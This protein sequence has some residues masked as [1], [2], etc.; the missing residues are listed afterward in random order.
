MKVFIPVLKNESTRLP[1]SINHKL[2]EAGLHQKVFPIKWKPFGQSLNIKSNL[3][4][5]KY[6]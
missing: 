1:T 3:L 5:L 4:K 2:S 6:N